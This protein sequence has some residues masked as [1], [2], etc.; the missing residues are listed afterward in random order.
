MLR[1]LQIFLQK[2]YKVQTHLTVNVSAASTT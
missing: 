1:L 2:A